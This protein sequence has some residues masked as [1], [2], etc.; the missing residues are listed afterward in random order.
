MI[1]LDEVLNA[2][3][4]E[5]E[6][7]EEVEAEE[8]VEILSPPS[9]ESVRLGLMGLLQSALEATNHTAALRDLDA[10]DVKVVSELMRSLKL[11]DDMSK[12]DALSQME[13]DD[14]MELARKVVL[15]N[16]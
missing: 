3:F 5:E 13:D 1:S 12:D 16:D 8:E 4:G 9:I 6:E 14:L 15:G 10:N 2:P 7:E 11:A